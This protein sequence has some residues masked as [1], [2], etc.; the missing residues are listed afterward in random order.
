MAAESVSMGRHA[1]ESD[2]VGDDAAADVAD[3]DVES[4]CECDGVGGAGHGGGDGKSDGEGEGEEG[5]WRWWCR[6]WAGW[7]E[8]AGAR[9]EECVV[10]GEYVVLGWNDDDVYGR[11][12]CCV[13]LEGNIRSKATG[14]RGGSP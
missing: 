1:R 9:K 4:D 7:W 6:S 8:G 12:C 14:W 10:R 5:V 11:D 13:L 3:A 2:V